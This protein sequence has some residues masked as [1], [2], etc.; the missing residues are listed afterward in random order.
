MCI[1]DRGG[2]AHLLWD[3]LVND[4]METTIVVD[5]SSEY[6]L[7][8]QLTKAPDYGQFD[9]YL[10]ERVI[11]SKI[12]LYATDVVL[13]DPVNVSGLKIDKGQHKIRFKLIG[14]NT[15]ASAY[16]KDR[17]LLGVDYIKII[18]M[19]PT[20]RDLKNNLA[21]QQVPEKEDSPVVIDSDYPGT[22]S[23]NVTLKDVKPILA[24]RCYGCHG[25]NGK[26]KGKINLKKVQ[27]MEDFLDDIELTQKI[28]DA[29]HFKEM[30]PE[31]E[32]Q[33][34]EKEHK[35]MS[36]LF[37]SYLDTYIKESGSLKQTVMRRMNRYEYN[38]AVRDLLQLKGDV[39]PLPE[40]AVSYTHLTL[41]TKA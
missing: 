9:I 36:A 23:P 37:R 8:F 1:R 24:S 19:L 20:A 39:Y 27:T 40:K 22:G 38:N 41:P 2:N 11:A 13:A 4:S 6:S 35:I 18:N 17:Y 14:S 33:L 26:V 5:K 10:G 32:K 30:P 25:D 29:L 15:K 21:E 7:Q 16:R 12:D 3:G 28:A 31:D 34:S